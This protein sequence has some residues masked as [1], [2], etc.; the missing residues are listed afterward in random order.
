M[1]ILLWGKSSVS[2]DDEE[3]K[4]G[5]VGSILLPVC[6]PRLPVANWSQFVLAVEE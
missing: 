3:P 1:E 2:V 4:H 5:R 6:S